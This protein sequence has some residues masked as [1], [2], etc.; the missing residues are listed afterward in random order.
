MQRCKAVSV[1]SAKGSSLYRPAVW[2]TAYLEKHGKHV[3]RVQ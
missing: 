1:A 3:L 2:Q